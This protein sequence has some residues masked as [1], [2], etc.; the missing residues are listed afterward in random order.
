MVNHSAVE[1]L[2]SSK[3]SYLMETL[4]SEKV[5]GTILAEFRLQGFLK[6][7]KKNNNNTYV[8]NNVI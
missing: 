3:G 6:E 2:L 4:A 1:K 5:K 7:K 8:L